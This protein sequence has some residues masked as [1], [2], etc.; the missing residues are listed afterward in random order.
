MA[1]NRPSGSPL[2]N[3]LSSW[4]EIAAYVGRGVRTVQ[5]W[6]LML[7]FP[8]RRPYR[9]MRSAV[10]A[11]PEEIDAWVAACQTRS[12]TIP[13][14]GRLNHMSAVSVPSSENPVRLY[15]GRH[16]EAWLISR[17]PSGQLKVAGL[18]R[19]A[20]QG[21]AEFLQEAPNDAN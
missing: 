6:E 13:A 11:V 3:V 1:T 18:N 21:G 16:D 20:A 17:L 15:V 5:R 19:S 9:H 4:K 2:N 12:T 8:V 10:L 7:G 14:D